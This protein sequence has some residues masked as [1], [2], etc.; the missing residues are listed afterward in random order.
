MAESKTLI[1]P[2]PRDQ[3]APPSDSPNGG[4]VSERRRLHDRFASRLQVNPELTRKL[5]SYQGNKAAP[6]FRWLKYKESFSHAL[7]ERCLDTLQPDSV[8][9]PFAGLGTVPLIAAGRGLD[10]SGIEISPVGVMAGRAIA[11]TA[12][13]LER[14]AFEQAARGLLAH[15]DADAQVRP[16]Y[17]FRHVRITESAFPAETET[18]LARAREY[19]SAVTAPEL[20][21]VLDL[22][23][24]SVLEQVSYTRKDGQYL[25]WDNRSGRPLRARLNKGPIPPLAHAL[26]VRLGEIAADII[27]LKQQYGGGNP[28]LLVGSSLELLRKLDEHSRDLV[29]TSPPYANRYDYTRTYALEL[30]WL[31][32]DQAQFSAL[33]QRMLSATV[34]NQSKRES[35]WAQYD[36]GPTIASATNMYDQQG[37]L[38]EVLEILRNVANELG[39]RHV[40]RLLEGYFFEMAV[41]I[42]ELGRIV[43]PGGGVVMVNDNVRYHGE[44][45]PV[46]LILS[47]FAEQAGFRCDR[48]EV[49]PRGKGNASQQMGRFGRQ[50]IRKCIYWWTREHG[51]LKPVRRSAPIQQIPCA[52]S[53]PRRAERNCATNWGGSCSNWRSFTTARQT[54]R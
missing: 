30:A 19:I 16:E 33:R 42:A 12:N 27:P 52:T 15:I 24:L 51:G 36:N 45:V 5:V 38:H 17:A 35:L 49:L 26:E 44:E 31:G 2:I 32:Y 23:C 7:V 37:A 54:C 4:P 48:I 34:E 6:G 8:L 28:D 22:A 13:D 11:H 53:Y 46:D 40:I 18:A 21:S 50:E 29:M 47:D 41:I 43:R 9:D 39:N 3:C 1:D 14:D 10:G 25:R 20:R